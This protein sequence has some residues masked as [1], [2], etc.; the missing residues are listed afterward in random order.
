MVD[1]TVPLGGANRR[2]VAGRY[3]LAGLLGS[4]GMAEVELAYD[5]RLDRQVALKLLHQ[6]YASDDAFVAR[7]R[8]EA[9]AAAS[10]NHPNI[11]GVYDTGDD[12]GRP[13]IV[14]EYVAGRS[15]RDV[16]AR[17]GVLPQRTAEIAVDAA[18]ALHY[19]AERGLV[20]R[21]VKPGNILIS[22]EGQVK[23]TDFGIARAVNAETVTQTAAVF[24]TAAY[25]APEQA[26]G[27]QVDARTDVYA[28][29]CV[30]YEMLTGRQPFAGD[31]AVAVA[32][33]H[34]SEAPVPPSRLSREVS[35]Q[36]EA[37]TLKAMA[38]APADRYQSAREFAADLQRA[39]GGVAVSAPPAAA[40]AT[41][42]ALPRDR[43]LV[44]AQPEPP[45]ERERERVVVD[46]RRRNRGLGWFLL[47]ALV[48]ALFAVAGLLLANVFDSADPIAQ[49]QVPDVTN[50]P[51]EEAQASLREAGFQ[52]EVLAPVENPTVAPNSVITTDPAPLSQAPEGSIVRLTI[53]AGPPLVEIPTL[54]GRTPQ[55]A[56]QAL[57]DVGLTVGEIREQ[58]S[59]EVEQGRVITTDPPPTTQVEQGR[60]VALLV[61][62]GPRTVTLPDVRNL[63]AQ[64]ARELLEAACEPRPCV[65]V[66]S[67]QRF[68]DDV[69]E[70]A[71]IRQ[72]PAPDTAVLVGSTVTLVVSAGPQA[73][74]E[75]TPSPTPT[76]SRT[77]T[78]TPSPSPSPSPSPTLLSPT[79]EPS[80]PEPTTTE[81]TT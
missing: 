23:V 58:P 2:R 43:T 74:P 46:D 70:G 5:E 30:L 7:F 76:P 9:Q 26:Q 47:V 39:L 22:D 57:T 17:E 50:R 33:K 64:R 15:L 65:Q 69:A 1:E 81:T 51:I 66:E 21:D 12:D 63:A 41:T 18:L 16:L 4:G 71:V 6:R 32:Y 10:L 62:T 68:D 13:F 79:D 34:V 38:K 31:S 35:P 48:I 45:Y 42:Q 55:E 61:S 73:P 36:L 44:G 19:A 80:S 59:D 53:S 27:G 29:G 40:Y 77:P 75:P 72:D 20:H 60:A 49:L 11:V 52:P 37:V 56:Q 14:M 24:G 67:V 28:L 54:T 78:P 3:V 8:R 25:V